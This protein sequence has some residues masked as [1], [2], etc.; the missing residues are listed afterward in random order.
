M[1]LKCEAKQK[2]LSKQAA[3]AH[4]QQDR[5]LRLE[6]Q[7]R[8]AVALCRRLERKLVHREG[9]LDQLAEA[10]SVIQQTGRRSK[11]RWGFAR[12]VLAPPAQESVSA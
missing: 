7:L 5:I 6:I 1:C 3:Q 10:F 4:R 2:M 12:T 11:H 9:K 8:E